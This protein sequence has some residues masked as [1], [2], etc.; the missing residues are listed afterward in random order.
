MRHLFKKTILA[1]VIV[2]GNMGILFAQQMPPVPM[3][4][5]VRVGKL[6]NGL[7]YYIRHNEKPENRVEFHIAQK[8]GSSKSHNNADWHTSWSTWPSTV[9]KTSPATNAAWVSYNGAKRKV[10]NSV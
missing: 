7:T 2:C 1:A 9:R 10:L 3:D 5:Q 4:A 8:V 6:D